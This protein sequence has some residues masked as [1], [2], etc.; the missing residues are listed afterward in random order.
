MPKKTAIKMYKYL[1]KIKLFISPSFGLIKNSKSRRF[2]LILADSILINIAFSLTYYFVD[3]PNI[4]LNPLDPIFA[5]VK[6]VPV[7]IGIFIYLTTGQYKGIT[8]YIRLSK[9][10]Y[11][12]FARNFLIGFILFLF[13]SIFKISYFGV[14]HC[15]FFVL[16]LSFLVSLCR[17]VLRDLLNIF[18]LNNKSNHKNVVIYGAGSAGFQLA[19]SLQ[20]SK[21][22][23]IQFFLDDNPN[24]WDRSINGIPILS[25][26]NLGKFSEEIDEVLIAIPSLGKNRRKEIINKLKEFNLRCFLIPSIDEITSGKAKIDDIRPVG[27]EELIGRKTV[28]IKKSMISDSFSRKNFLITGAGGSIGSEIIR[29]LIQFKPKTVVLLDNNEP[30][31]YKINNELTL[32]IQNETNFFPLLGDACDKNLILNILNKYNI[33]YIFHAAAYKHVP[34]VENNKL[35]GIYNNVFSTLNICRASLES[36]VRKMILISTDKAV[37]PTNVMGASKRLAE[38]II[39]AFENKFDKTGEFKLIKNNHKCF[40]LVRFGNVLGSSGSVLPLFKKQ[41]EKGGPI[42][43]TDTKM[44]RYF[45]TI[46]EAAQLVLQASVLSKGGDLFLLDMGEPVSIFHLAKQ[47]INLSGLKLKNNKNP[48]GDIEIV[49]TGIRDGEKLYEELLIDAKSKKTEHPLIYTAKEKSI[50]YD[51][52]ITKLKIMEESIKTQNLEVTLDI[53][54]ELVPEWNLFESF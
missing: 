23:S 42:T 3:Y 49:T 22:K 44:V 27:I 18:Y 40:T 2:L 17:L 38:L 52:L 33:D 8:K 46:P 45:M 31:L 20:I 37:R 39:Q 41:I 35:Q 16:I 53:L 19:S 4:S 29:Q 21:E 6:I 15:F 9:F 47:L 32:L 7:M 48:D 14:D 1:S 50:H 13:F 12:I 11:F 28:A 30:S 51:F 36:N 24:L 10:F 25:P 5:L 43:I 54:K 26:D 34:L